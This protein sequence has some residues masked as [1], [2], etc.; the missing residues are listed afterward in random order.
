MKATVKIERWNTKRGREHRI[1]T[2]TPDGCFYDTLSLNQ[3]V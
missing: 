3:L 2:R 1:V